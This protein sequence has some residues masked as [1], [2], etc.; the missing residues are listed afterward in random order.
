MDALG[1]YTGFALYRNRLAPDSRVLSFGEVRDR[2]QVFVDGAPV[3]VLQRDHHDRS[4][5][6][7]P[8]ERTTSTSW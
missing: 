4:I 6:L 5:G 7:P 3:G 8:G 1:Q 2:A